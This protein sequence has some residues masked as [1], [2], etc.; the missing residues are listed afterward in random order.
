MKTRIQQ[1]IDFFKQRAKNGSMVDP[2]IKVFEAKMGKLLGQ[3][4]VEVDTFI[5]NIIQT[6][7][8]GFTLNKVR[9]PTMNF[10]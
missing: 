9:A 4:S 8:K 2:S 6:A 1:I 5:R 3:E 7:E 10:R